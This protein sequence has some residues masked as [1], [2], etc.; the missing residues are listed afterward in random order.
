MSK[1]SPKCSCLSIF[2][3]LTNGSDPLPFQWMGRQ[4]QSYE[5]TLFVD[6]DYPQLMKK[7]VEIILDIP[8]L[9]DLLRNAT[10]ATSSETV[11]LRSDSYLALGC[12]LRDLA[13]LE[14]TLSQ[15][16][17]S[18]ECVF[19]VTAEVSVT[20]MDVDAANALIAWVA[21]FDNGL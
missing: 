5:N 1:R 6:V 11:L 17:V 14:S 20:Y 16:L 2:R 21:R 15:E 7:K 18:S 19:L 12:D 4:K 9:H 3:G 10:A 8:E 13:K